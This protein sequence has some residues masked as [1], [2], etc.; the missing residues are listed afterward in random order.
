MT[1]LMTCAACG[2]K[3]HPDPNLPRCEVLEH[4]PDCA[5]L[6]ALRDFDKENQ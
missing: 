1:G 6:A 2:A 4:L 3:S 5:Y